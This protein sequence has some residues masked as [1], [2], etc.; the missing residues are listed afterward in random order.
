MW[1]IV[2]LVSSKPA[3]LEGLEIDQYFWAILNNW[4]RQEIE[5]V[6]IDQLARVKPIVMPN[7]VP[8]IKDEPGIDNGKL[9][10]KIV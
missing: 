5:E 10:A 3:L 9:S 8:A 1:R 4:Q 7:S 2:L 6:T